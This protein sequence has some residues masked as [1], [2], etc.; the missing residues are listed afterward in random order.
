[1]PLTSRLK[2]PGSLNPTRSLTTVT[3]PV[4]GATTIGIVNDVVLHFDDVPGCTSVAGVSQV[5]ALFCRYESATEMLRLPPGPATHFTWIGP[6]GA[7]QAGFPG[8]PW[9]KSLSRSPQALPSRFDQVPLNG[10]GNVAL[11][12]GVPGGTGVVPT[13]H[14]SPPRWPARRPATC[15]PSQRKSRR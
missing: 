9:P 2:S 10:G 5:P 1:M 3:V 12:G 4:G 15:R 7:I 6:V 13:E 14:V 11:T 8:M